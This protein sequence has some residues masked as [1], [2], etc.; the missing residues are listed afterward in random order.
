MEALFA[1]GAITRA[2]PAAAKPRP[3]RAPRRRAGNP[4]GRGGPR[5]HSDTVA[6]IDGDQV[7]QA[8]INLCTTRSM[9]RWKPAAACAPVGP[10]TARRSA[11]RWMTRTRTGRH[12]EP[13]RAVFHD[14]NARQRHRLG[15]QPSDRRSPRRSLT[16]ENRPDGVRGCRATLRLPLGDPR[17]PILG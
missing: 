1:A 6:N 10:W 14:E 5:R 13:F 17:V 11:S 16:L 3:A 4:A 7:E 15:A 12:H 2:D 9:P 8:L